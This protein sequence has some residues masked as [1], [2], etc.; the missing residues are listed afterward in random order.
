M[1]NVTVIGAQW[2]DE[3]KGKVIDLLASRAG[4]VVRFHGGNNAGHTLVLKG[5]KTILHLVPSGILNPNCQCLIGD[6]VVIDPAVLMSEIQTLESKGILQSRNR[7]HISEKA[8]VIMPY[9]IRIDQLRET[10]SKKGAIGTTGRGIG[11]AYEDK[12]GRF[13]IRMADFIRPEIFEERLKKF[14]PE[15]NRYLEK[16]LEGEGFKMEEVLLKY[17]VYA[18][19][20]KPFVKNS[21]A[22]LEGWQKE[23]RNLLWEGAQGAGLDIDHGTYPFVTSSNTLAGAVA[24]GCGVAAEAVGHVL[25][26]TKAYATRVGGGPFP[27]EL[28]D[29]TADRMRKA[30]NEFGST[31]GRPRRCGWLDIA[32]LRY[33]AKINGIRGLAVTKLDVLS[34]FEKLQVCVGY[35]K[36][37][38]THEGVPVTVEDWSALS[39]VYETLPGWKEDI[40]NAKRWEDLPVSAQSYIKKMEV[41]TGIPIEIVSVGPG[42]EQTI[43]LK[44]SYFPLP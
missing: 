34:G 6:G 23:K 18:E 42:R 32:W 13:G 28:L 9:H 5:E 1:V 2:G 15:K 19:F 22:I 41:W 14:L 8:H 38:K 17:N 4:A 16:V 40:S 29:A 44:P 37:G 11:P 27:T 21:L 36:N 12:V 30:G 43:V 25:G 26:I 10:R 35:E 7:L 24:T 31:T 39:P 20:L 33:A 3:G